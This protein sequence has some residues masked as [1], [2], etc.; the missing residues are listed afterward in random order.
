LPVE[1]RAIARAPARDEAVREVLRRLPPWT[2]TA[3]V[4]FRF[5]QLEL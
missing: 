4:T 2:T 5:T 1:L 3:T